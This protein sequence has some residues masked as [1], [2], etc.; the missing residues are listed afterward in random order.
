MLVV[1]NFPAGISA[2]DSQFLAR[3]YVLLCV[4]SYFRDITLGKKLDYDRKKMA[5]DCLDEM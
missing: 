2:F 3:S 5:G 4:L 1:M